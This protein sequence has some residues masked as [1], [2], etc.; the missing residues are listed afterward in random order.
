M[1]ALS[2]PAGKQAKERTMSTARIIPHHQGD[3]HSVAYDSAQF[4]SDEGLVAVAKMGDGTVFDELHKRHAE[5]M[6][7][8]AHRII[9]IVRMRRMRSKRVF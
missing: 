3:R 4:I 5:R 1:L 8:V 6:F 9:D 2:T 7:R